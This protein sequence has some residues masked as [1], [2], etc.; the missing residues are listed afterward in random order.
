MPAKKAFWWRPEDGWRNFGDEISAAILNELGFPVELAALPESEIILGGSILSHYMGEYDPGAAVWGPG[1]NILE[2]ITG[3]KVLAVRGRITAQYVEG[4][5]VLGD[6][7]LLTPLA[8]P[9]PPVRYGV[10]VVRHWSDKNEYP[11]ADIVI[12]A[13]EEVH[14]VIEKIASCRTICATSLHGLIVA[15]AYGIPCMRLE[16]DDLYFKHK[17]ADFQTALE[18]PLPQVQTDLIHAL[19]KV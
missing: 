16:K 9:R 15:T 19:E 3:L 6:P 12:D 14:T 5:P 17:W 13:T 7:G 1:I 8:F 2:P 10:G 4:D 11:W 18:K